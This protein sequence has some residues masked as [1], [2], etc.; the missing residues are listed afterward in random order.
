MVREQFLTFMRGAILALPQTLKAALRLAEDPD[1]PDEA[2]VLVAGAIVHWLSRTNSIPGV[3]GGALAYVDDVLVLML[4][5]ERLKQLAPEADDRLLADSP[6]LFETLAADLALTREYFGGA[7]HVLEQALGR[8]TKLKHMGRTPQQCVKDEAAT[9]MLYEE[10]LAALVD[11]DPAP[12]AVGRELKDLD[13]LVDEL[14]K[15][16]G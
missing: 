2:R 11:Y 16:A 5:C 10:V 13:A 12:E 8:V 15:K 14:R 7:I 4:A 3:R 6:E 1:I 9:T